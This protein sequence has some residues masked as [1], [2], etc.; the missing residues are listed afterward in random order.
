MTSTSISSTSNHDM[1]IKVNNPEHQD[2]TS[3]VFLVEISDE[4]E[5]KF[6]KLH[7]RP[8]FQGVFSDLSLR[9]T[10][11]LIKTSI[12]R[13]TF[14]EYCNLPGILSERFFNVAVAGSPDKRI[15][16]HA[17]L[18]LMLEVYGSS[19]EKKMKLAFMM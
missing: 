11:S 1:R 19:L 18:D 7:L 9:S 8:Y 10:T 15:Y 12:D 5:S 2:S 3:L 4:L 14:I 6:I 13:V 17:F 16:E